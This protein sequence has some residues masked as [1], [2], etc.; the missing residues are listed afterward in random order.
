[1]PQERWTK[2]A[3]AALMLIFLTPVAAMADGRPAWVHDAANDR[4]GRIYY[5]ER[6]NIDG[7]RDERITV[8]RR[9]ATQLEVYKE[10]GLCQRAAL[11]SAELDLATLTTPTITG[12]TL[13]PDARHVDFAFIESSPDR[14]RLSL[15]VELPDAEIRDEAAVR[16]TPWTLYDFDFASLTVTTPHI[17]RRQDGF[18]FGMVLLWA[19][20]GVPDP[21][22]WMGELRARYLGAEERLGTPA[23]HYRLTGN[24]LQGAASTGAAGELWLDRRDGHIVDALLP[25]PNHPGY[26]DFRLKL[27]NVSDGGD[28]EW[29]ALLE[30]HFAGCS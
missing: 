3:R 11:V 12:G 29:T 2:T 4:I 25:V 10:N 22:Y 20:P 21:F 17:E 9:S 15:R 7:T 5:Y 28:A 8:F 27:L 26:R 19:D 13:Q 1:M 14:Q 23:E 24:A 30:A 6:S 18:S 16:A